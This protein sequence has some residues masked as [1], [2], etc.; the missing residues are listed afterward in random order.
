MR[1]TPGYSFR[2]GAVAVACCLP[3]QEHNRTLHANIPINL[4]PFIFSFSSRLFC[5]GWHSAAWLYDEMSSRSGL[6]Q[7]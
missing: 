2:T 3:A 4:N 6:S 7:R 1:L 5:M